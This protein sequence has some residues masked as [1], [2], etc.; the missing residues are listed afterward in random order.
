MAEG[1]AVSFQKK[2]FDVYVKNG[3][4]NFILAVIGS[5]K[6]STEGVL[7]IDRVKASDELFL[8]RRHEFVDAK[9]FFAD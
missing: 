9:E 5:E 6:I 1:I 4:G 3:D 2:G 7:H 8:Q